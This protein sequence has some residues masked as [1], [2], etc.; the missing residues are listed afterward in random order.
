MQV[1]GKPTATLSMVIVADRTRANI[2][3]KRL[4]LPAKNYPLPYHKESIR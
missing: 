1:L 3:S 4:Q 2:S